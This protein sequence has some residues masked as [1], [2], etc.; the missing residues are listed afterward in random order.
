MDIANTA[1]HTENFCER[2]SDGE[3]CEMKFVSKQ[4]IDYAIWIYG[5]EYWLDMQKTIKELAQE[6]INHFNKVIE[7]C[8]GREFNWMRRGIFERNWKTRSCPCST[9]D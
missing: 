6:P 8:S 5:D 3:I 2:Y 4:D 7:L 1:P 9:N